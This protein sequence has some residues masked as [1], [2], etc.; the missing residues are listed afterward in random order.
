M[1]AEFLEVDFEEKSGSGDGNAKV[2]SKEF[3]DAEMALFREQAKD[4]DII[5][6]AL[7]PVKPTPKLIPADMVGL[8]KL[9]VLLSI[10]RQR[11]AVSVN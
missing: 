9:G 7:I 10:L 11:T 4:V 5:T 2:M 6:T 1:G 8:M 3:I